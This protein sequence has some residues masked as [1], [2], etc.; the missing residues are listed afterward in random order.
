[1]PHVAAD[2]SER[3]I[4][5]TD[6][7]ATSPDVGDLDFLVADL[8]TLRIAIPDSLDSTI[9]LKQQCR[10]VF[11]DLNEEEVANDLSDSLRSTTTSDDG[12]SS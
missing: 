7:S 12:E 3:S 5:G 4:Q 11:D 6:S 10:I 8:S 1:L 9:V 2:S